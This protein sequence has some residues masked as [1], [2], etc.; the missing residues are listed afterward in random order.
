MCVSDTSSSHGVVCVSDTSS[1]HGVVC[2]GY[3][4]H[5]GPIK[6][7]LDPASFTNGIT[8]AWVYAKDPLLLIEKNSP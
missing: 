3:M 4:F 5:S 8:K 6:L 1:S 2:T 7:F